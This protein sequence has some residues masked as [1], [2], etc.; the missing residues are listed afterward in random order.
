MNFSKTIQILGFIAVIAFTV[1][2]VTGCKSSTHDPYVPIWY[3]V[4][5]DYCGKGNP[6]PGCNYYADGYQVIDVEDPYFDSHYYL[7]Y[8]WWEYYD[9]YGYPR[10][11][12]GWAWLSPDNVLYDD[13]GRALNEDGE[14]QDRD[15]IAVVAA[16]ER[17]NVETAGKNF[18]ERYALAE[19][20]GV[21][22]AKTLNDWA[23]LGKSRAR[24]AQDIADFS[25]RL[26]GVD[27]NT[28]S[29]SLEKAKSG[30]KTELSNN[31]AQMA[32]FWGTSPE[33]A[34]EVL[35]NAYKQELRDF[36]LD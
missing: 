2:S 22:V 13:W 30:D 8:G 5:G 26:F 21:Q 35:K 4:Y 20:T 7:E 36:N 11:Y 12:I 15:I 32:N 29:V 3:D 24:T 34:K 28:V 27:F 17:Q 16:K 31:I 18:A 6:T 10:D 9:T 33:T 1:S 19:D 14:T 23:V 25:K